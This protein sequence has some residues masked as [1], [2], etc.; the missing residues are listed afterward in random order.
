MDETDPQITSRQLAWGLWYV[1]HREQLRK[2]HV[3]MLIVVAA[4]AWVFVIYGAIV[5]FFLEGRSLH[6]DL[7]ALV[8]SG[9]ERAALVRSLRASQLQMGEVALVASGGGPSTELRAGAYDAA[10]RVVNPNPQFLATITYAIVIAGAEDQEE[11]AVVLPG[12]ERWLTRLHAVSPASPRGA[13]LAIRRIAWDRITHRDV[14]RGDARAY[15]A[16]RWNVAVTESTFLPDLQRAAFALENRSAYSLRDV[17]I[18]VLLRRGGLIT[19]VNR[20]VVPSLP[21]AHTVRAAATWFTPTFGMTVEVYPFV[22]VFDPA[23]FVPL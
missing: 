22:N 20:I 13:T 3:I 15:L 5:P 2:T 1:R 11:T 19:G 21:A 8:A 17:E 9:R 4:C 10:A 23:V 7:T 12:K 14:D 18:V 6:R 16:E